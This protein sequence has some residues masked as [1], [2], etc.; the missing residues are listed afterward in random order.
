M[1]RPGLSWPADI[2]HNYTPKALQHLVGHDIGLLIYVVARLSFL[3]SVVT[4]FPLMVSPPGH[5]CRILLLNT[6]LM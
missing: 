5:L 1:L 2:L 3:T 4:L 6:K